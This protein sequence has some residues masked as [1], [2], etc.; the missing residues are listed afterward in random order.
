VKKYFLITPDFLRSLVRFLFVFSI[1][2]AVLNH[3]NLKFAEYNLQQEQK[4]LIKYPTACMGRN[5]IESDGFEQS[6][7]VNVIFGWN[8]SNY[9]N[10][11]MFAFLEK[12]ETEIKGKLKINVNFAQCDQIFLQKS[13]KVDDLFKRIYL[14]SKYMNIGI[15][16]KGFAFHDG[17]IDSGFGF[18][19]TK[20][21]GVA[22]IS[23]YLIDPRSFEAY[24]KNNLFEKRLKKLLYRYIG[25]AYM[26]KSPSKDPRS[27]LHGQITSLSDLDSREERF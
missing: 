11:Q 26:K 20:N 25:L 4:L 8:Q 22:V 21:F 1:S 15:F 12:F 14:N 13:E 2:Y 18:Y 19:S 27:L 5:H 9:L 23:N 6:I 7:D 24:D 17:K 10:S 16:G 3:I